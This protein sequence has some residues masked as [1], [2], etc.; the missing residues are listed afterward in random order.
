MTG[1]SSPEEVVQRQLEAYNAKDLEAWLATYAPD[2]K[3]FE[4]PGK[5]LA[6]GHDEIRARTA[7]RFTEPNL[8][9]RLLKRTVMS[10]VVIDHE[11]VTRTFPEGPGHVELVCIYVVERGR[12]QSASFVIGPAVMEGTQKE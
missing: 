1:W 9:A 11:D 4:H 5:L 3:Q 2:A 8:H 7:P 12:I 10:N 6:S